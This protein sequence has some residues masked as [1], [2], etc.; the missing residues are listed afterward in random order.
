[1]EVATNYSDQ[2]KSRGTAILYKEGLRIKRCQRWQK[3]KIPNIIVR[4]IIVA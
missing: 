2:V 3:V 4:K 1:M